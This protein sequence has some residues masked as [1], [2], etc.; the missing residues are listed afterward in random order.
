MVLLYVVLFGTHILSP[1]LPTH[2]VAVPNGLHGCL[3]NAHWLAIPLGQI[4]NVVAFLC[5]EFAIRDC[6]TPLS[7]GPRRAS[8]CR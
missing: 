7:K 2:F 1:T 8:I 4:H 6:G 3:N 5:L